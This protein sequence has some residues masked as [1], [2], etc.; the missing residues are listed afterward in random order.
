MSPE[1][2]ITSTPA[3]PHTERGIPASSAQSIPFRYPPSACLGRQTCGWSNQQLHIR[4]QMKTEHGSISSE[5]TDSS[6]QTKSHQ[7]AGPIQMY[8]ALFSLSPRAEDG[9]LE[10]P[11]STRAYPNQYTRPSKCE[12]A[13]INAACQHSQESD[14]N[15]PN[16]EDHAIWILVCLSPPSFCVCLC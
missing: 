5:S 11:R 15:P 12:M 8:S 7:R 3:R 9:A 10:S 16:S 14:D 2:L 1:S 6:S 4:D 13:E